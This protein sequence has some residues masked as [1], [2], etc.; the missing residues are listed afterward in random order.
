[1][2]FLMHP[3][4]GKSLCGIVRPL[5][6]KTLYNFQQWISWFSHRWRTQRIAICNVNC[7]IQWIIESLNA[8]CALWYSEGHACLSVIK[9]FSTS[10]LLF[11]SLDF[12]GPCWCHSSAPLKCISRTMKGPGFGLIIISYL[13]CCCGPSCVQLSNGPFG[14]SPC[15]ACITF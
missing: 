13:C 4:N 11:W 2:L 8:P 14:L 1:M 15:E 3:M 7:R 12:G 6:S 5:W 10:N 9:K